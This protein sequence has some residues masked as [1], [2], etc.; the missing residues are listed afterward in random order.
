MTDTEHSKLG[1]VNIRVI[2]GRKSEDDMNANGCQNNSQGQEKNKDLR[3][4][5]SAQHQ[6]YLYPVA[7]SGYQLSPLE[8]DLRAS[9]RLQVRNHNYEQAI[10]LLTQLIARNPHNAQDYNNRGLMRFKIGQYDQA[11]EDYNQALRLD[12]R[13][14]SAYNNR[15]NYYAAQGDLAAAIA[16]YDAA[17]DFNPGNLRASINQAIAFRQLG[18]YDLA[19]DNL[20]LALVLGRRLKGRI[21]LERGRTYH[22]RGDWNC[23]V[24]DYKRALEQLP[25]TSNNFSYRQQ[26]QSWLDELLQPISA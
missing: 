13:L 20:D 2:S 1:E 8:Q 5:E 23:A 12:S 14:D 11:L 24:A 21:Y 16:D 7:E 25:E 19:L 4:S 22:L 9:V 18:L 26:V 6:G 17:L 15:A 3:S 10:T